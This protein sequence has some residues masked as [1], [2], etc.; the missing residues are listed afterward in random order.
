MLVWQ[1]GF[2][3][4]GWVVVAGLLAQTITAALLFRRAHRALFPDASAERFTPFV[5]MLLAPPTAIRAH[6]LL[7]RHLLGAFHPLAVA[8]G[9]CS[10]A[11]FE[12]L[13][14]RTLLDLRCPMLPLCPAGTP[15]AARAAQWFRRSVPGAG[16]P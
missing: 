13:A 9:L 8:Q 12:E 16:A 10:P 4:R 11:R 14:R 5:T 7:S 6:D 1:F 15:A 3:H 2:G